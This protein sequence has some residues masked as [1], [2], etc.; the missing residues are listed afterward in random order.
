MKC[1]GWRRGGNKWE[2]R[3]HPFL[4][5]SITQVLNTHYV[6]GTIIA[7]D[8]LD[9][10]AF[11]EFPSPVKYRVCGEDDSYLGCCFFFFPTLYLNLLN[12][13]SVGEKHT[14]KN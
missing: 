10:V 7:G 3:D 6:L 4:C 9:V 8:A 1:E 2:Q 12:L 14:H 13:L 5:P 11:P